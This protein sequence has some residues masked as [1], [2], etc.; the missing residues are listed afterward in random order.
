MYYA[1]IEALL[2]HRHAHRAQRFTQEGQMIKNSFIIAHLN[3]TSSYPC[4]KRGLVLPFATGFLVDGVTFINFDG[5]RSAHDGRFS[6]TLLK[7]V[8]K[9]ADGVQ[10]ISI[11]P[12]SLFS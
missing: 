5:T 10:T 1:G 8:W 7:I 2:D 12:E 6:L 3:R 4:T 11:G 9:S